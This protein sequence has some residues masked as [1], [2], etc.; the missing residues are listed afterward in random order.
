M[1]IELVENIDKSIRKLNSTLVFI[2]EKG[3]EIIDDKVHSHDRE[4]DQCH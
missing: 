1:I 2:D 4:K 3:I